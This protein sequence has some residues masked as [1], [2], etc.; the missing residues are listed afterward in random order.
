MEDA[1]LM[2]ERLTQI[3]EPLGFKAIEPKYE[4]AVELKHVSGDGRGIFIRFNEHNQFKCSGQ[5][6]HRYSPDNPKRIQVSQDRSDE[7]IRK[8]V[9][10][11]LLDDYETLYRAQVERL[12]K[13]NDAETNKKKAAEELVKEFGGRISEHHRDEV[14]LSIS[15]LYECRLNHNGTEMNIRT[16]QVSMEVGKKI[17]RLLKECSEKR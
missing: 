3:F 9:E 1:K 11:R 13:D 4:H 10:R 16:H 7:A 14:Y 5:Y 12:N 15:N 2:A 8:D 6:P 17:L